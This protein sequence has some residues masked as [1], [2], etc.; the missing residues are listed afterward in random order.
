MLVRYSCR[1]VLLR[2]DLMRALGDLPEAMEAIRAH[3][4]Q[5]QGGKKRCGHV[6]MRV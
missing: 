6:Y 5:R 1:Y 3:A 2:E 4:L